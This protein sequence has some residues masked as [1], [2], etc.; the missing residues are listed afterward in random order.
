MPRITPVRW[1]I[2]ECVFMK[3]GFTFERETGSHRSYTKDGCKRPV[4]IPKYDAIGVEIIKSNMRTAEMDRE[5]YFKL[6]G[7][8]R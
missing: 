6:L 7:E 8:C 3:F 2:L 5:T 4:I 1:Q